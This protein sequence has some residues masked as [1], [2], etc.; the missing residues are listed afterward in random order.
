M[1]MEFQLMKKL[2]R[3]TSPSMQNLETNSKKSGM[4]KKNPLTN[5]MR[6]TDRKKKSD[7]LNFCFVK[8]SDLFGELYIILFCFPQ[9]LISKVLNP[10]LFGFP[11]FRVSFYEC[12]K[13]ANLLYQTVLPIIVASLIASI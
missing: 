2:N 12:L 1:K 7:V 11:V 9:I 5:I 8:F 6:S 13:Q 4:H 3:L 10:L